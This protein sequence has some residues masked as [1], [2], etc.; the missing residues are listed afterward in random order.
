MD[1]EG[2]EQAM[3][4]VDELF[5][6]DDLAHLSSSGDS[7]LTEFIGNEEASLPID[8]VGLTNSER[9]DSVSK[10]SPTTSTYS[11]Q[12]HSSGH[13]SSDFD[14]AIE[15]GRRLSAP[16]TPLRLRISTKERIRVLKTE[17]SQLA[18]ILQ[19]AQSRNQSL[20]QDI[21]MPTKLTKCGCKL[22]WEPIAARQ[23]KH[24]EKSEAENL[25]LR[26]LVESQCRYLRSVQRAIRR[27]PSPQV[28]VKM[29]FCLSD[30]S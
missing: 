27:Q 16:R 30:A 13:V 24:R 15:I 25:H 8:L 22:M 6:S 3:R 4:Y 12:S 9:K 14:A 21:T 5:G 11:S 29:L 10:L 19:A 23:R 20:H 7:F 2:F 26:K 28:H 18:V 1:T 17:A